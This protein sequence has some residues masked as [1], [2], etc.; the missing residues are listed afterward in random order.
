MRRG[1]ATAARPSPPNRQTSRNPPRDPSV[2]LA[3]RPQCPLASPCPPAACWSPSP[4]IPLPSCP[5]HRSPPSPPAWSSPTQ[6][7][8][9]P[10]G[11]RGPA[12]LPSPAPPPTEG[13]AAGTTPRIPSTLPPCWHFEE[14]TSVGL[15][16]ILSPFWGGG[17][18]K[19][20]TVLPGYARFPLD[21][22][23]DPG[24][25]PK[26]QGSCFPRPDAGIR[27][28]VLKNSQEPLF[29]LVWKSPEFQPGL[30]SFAKH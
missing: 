11:P 2:A 20:L 13:A 16:R 18:A 19:G 8:G 28:L 14:T 17:F 29:P 5:P 21:S 12:S 26:L 15:S 25:R 6:R 23:C 4:C 22:L 9:T 7:R 3:G 10:M 24:F 30:C 1:A 27:F